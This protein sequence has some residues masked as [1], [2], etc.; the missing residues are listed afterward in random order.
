[1]ITEEDDEV[2][3]DDL[4]DEGAASGLVEPTPEIPRAGFTCGEVRFKQGRA[5][6]G[7]WKATEA[8]APDARWFCSKTCL[9]NWLIA[10]EGVDLTPWRASKA[11]A[12]LAGRPWHDLRDMTERR[13]GL[14]LSR[15]YN[16]LVTEVREQARRDAQGDLARDL[17]F[18]LEG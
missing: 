16:G 13:L 14:L 7:W 11:L 8:S 12:A 5:P 4:E 17:D 18:S 2:I 3:L 1:M 15:A 9:V 6:T 10:D